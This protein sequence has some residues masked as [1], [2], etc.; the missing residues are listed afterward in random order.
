MLYFGLPSPKRTGD[1][2]RPVGPTPVRAIVPAQRSLLRAFSGV[3]DKNCLFENDYM[4][5]HKLRQVLDIAFGVHDD[6]AVALGRRIQELGGRLSRAKA[7]L[8][9]SRASWWSRLPP[10]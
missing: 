2:T 9:A 3:A 6:R 8:A 7:E 4:R 10:R 1:F 5:K